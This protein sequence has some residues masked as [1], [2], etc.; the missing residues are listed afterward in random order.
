MERA[1]E[2]FSLLLAGGLL[3]AQETREVE[4][5]RPAAPA[6]TAR[7]AELDRKHRARVGKENAP[8]ER[9]EDLRGSRSSSIR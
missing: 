2:V 5:T 8:R 3:H 4:G 7:L 9:I 6:A 1:L